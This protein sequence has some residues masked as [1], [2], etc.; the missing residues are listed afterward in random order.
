MNYGTKAGQQY[1]SYKYENVLLTHHEKL[2]SV[3]RRD[4]RVSVRMRVMLLQNISCFLCYL[5]CVLRHSHNADQQNAPLLHF[6]SHSIF[7][8][9]MFETREL[10]FRKTVVTRTG[11]VYVYSVCLHVW[12]ILITRARFCWNYNKRCFFLYISY[13]V[14]FKFKKNLPSPAQEDGTDRGFRNVGF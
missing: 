12:Y 8:M 7:Y 11:T 9:Y 6:I 2:R 1:V 10:T 14:I 5:Y 3:Y 4:G 13:I